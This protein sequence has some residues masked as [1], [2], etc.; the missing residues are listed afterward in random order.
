MA[1]QVRLGMLTPSSNTVLEP[2]TAAM[3]SGVA[4]V[5]AHFARFRVEKITL[6][7]DANAQFEG[8]AMLA[9]GELLGDAHVDAICWN[10]TSGGWLGFD[11]D[12]ALCRAIAHA[13][14]V[15]ATSATLALAEAFRC[16][17]AERV[18]FVTPYLSE[19]QDKIVANYALEGFE[20]IAEE[21]FED[22]GNFSFAL[23]PEQRTATAVRRVAAAGPDAIAIFCTNLN[24]ARLVPALEAE[25]GVPVIDSVAVALWQSLRLA[26]ADPQAVI[27][28]GRLFEEA[29]F[30]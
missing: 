2:L 24:A 21:H 11:A 6:E 13:T 12:R 29:A 15:P 9:A 3:L 16:A 8:G 7:D 20:T 26:G 10:G 1:K 18:A 28:W 17:S 14:G 5:S 30:A 4:G 27:G 25:L 23:I 19:I 22:E